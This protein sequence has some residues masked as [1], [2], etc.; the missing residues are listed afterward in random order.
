MNPAGVR[1]LRRYPFV[2][3]MLDLAVAGCGPGGIEDAL[4]HQGRHRFGLPWFEAPRPIGFGLMIRPIRSRPAERSAP[5]E[6]PLGQ[7]GSRAVCVIDY[8]ALKPRS[9]TR[10]RGGN[11][12]TRRSERP[13]AACLRGPAARRSGPPGVTAGARRGYNAA[14]SWRGERWGRN[15]DGL[16]PAPI[17]CLSPSCAPASG[18][19]RPRRPPPRP[20]PPRRPRSALR[21]AP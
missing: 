7:P 18:W 20:L 21:P 13:G 16:A 5:I 8:T 1:G 15:S 11:L 12:G 19:R 4:L 3:A 6:R 17:V 14:P 9:S 2:T 10:W